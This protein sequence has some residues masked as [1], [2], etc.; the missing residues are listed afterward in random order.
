[1]QYEHF[2]QP[3][4]VRWW[5]A[6]KP[7]E[8]CSGSWNCWKGW[9]SNAGGRFHHVPD[10]LGG[11]SIAPNLIHSTYSAEDRPAVDSSRRDPLIDDA[12]RRHWHRSGTDGLSFP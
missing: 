6:S 10:R 7:R 4:K 3:W 5:W 1:M 9:E 8:Q 2:M 12:C 11:D